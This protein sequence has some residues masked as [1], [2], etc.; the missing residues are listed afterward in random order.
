MDQESNAPRV[1]VALPAYNAALFLVQSI[2]SVLKQDFEDFELLLLDDGS[3]DCTLEIAE[4]Y[5]ARDSR[6]RVISR[7]NR[8][9]PASLNQLFA[10]AR[11]PLVARMDADD[12]CEPSRFSKQ[13]AF[14][15]EHPD[16]GI[17]GCH[18]TAIDAAGRQVPNYDAKVPCTHDEIV[19]ALPRYCPF[20]HP[21][22]M[23]RRDLVTAV[24][25]YRE[26][27]R[28]AEDYDL[29]LRLS[30]ITCMANL[31]EALLKYRWHFGQTSSMN[32]VGQARTAAIAWLA[33]L[34]RAAGRP[35]PTDGLEVLPA[36]DCLDVLF[37][38]GCKD[39][40]RKRVFKDV[41]SAPSVREGG[42]WPIA[43]LCACARSPGEYRKLGRLALRHLRARRPLVALRILA[44]LLGAGV[45]T[46]ARSFPSVARD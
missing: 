22:V 31:S 29:W 18:V 20:F 13:V 46:I 24:G 10:A 11:A 2:E 32:M 34:R 41:I 35:D 28:D 37:G 1:S 14:L 4:S 40:V 12:L 3:T 16:Y 6:I 9:L 17:V 45:S 44:G 33:H 27:Y 8:G 38:V 19:A 36:D 7:E 5:A 39:Y 25:G 42:G 15:D 23:I 26:M 43:L 30:G 21:A